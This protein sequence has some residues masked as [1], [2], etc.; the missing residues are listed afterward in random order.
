MIAI[1]SEN[2]TNNEISCVMNTTENPS[3][4]R[5]RIICPR[6]CRCTTTSKAVVGSSMITTEGSSTK[7]IAIITRCLIPPDS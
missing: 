2:S 5:N 3:S 4:P 7:A 1:R 6:I